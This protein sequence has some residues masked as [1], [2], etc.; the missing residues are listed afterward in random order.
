MKDESA[1]FS[2]F[3]LPPSSL[4]FVGRGALYGDLRASTAPISIVGAS[5]IKK[6]R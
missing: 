4:L 1:R 3:I 6:N 2:S 5:E